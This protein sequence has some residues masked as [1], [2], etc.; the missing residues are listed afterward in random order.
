[1]SPLEVVIRSPMYSLQNG[2]YVDEILQQCVSSYLESNGHG[3]FQPNF[4]GDI[5]LDAA[6]K[7]LTKHFS[8]SFHRKTQSEFSTK[9]TR[10]VD[11][12]FSQVGVGYLSRA[13]NSS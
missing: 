7:T 13:G 5:G 10:N 4:L 1:M 9:R 12:F 11:L 2:S 6:T 3:R 8:T